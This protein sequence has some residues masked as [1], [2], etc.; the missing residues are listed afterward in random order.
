MYGVKNQGSK[1]IVA[2]SEEKSDDK[3]VKLLNK[4]KI[5]YFRGSLK[6]F[7]Q[8]IYLLQKDIMMMS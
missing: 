4:E 5:N 3:L 8:D 6:M 1:V 7:F 2:T